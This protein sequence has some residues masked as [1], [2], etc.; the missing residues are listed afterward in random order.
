MS[1]CALQSV[2]RLV[3]QQSAWLFAAL[4]LLHSSKFEDV[5]K[6]CACFDSVAL[7]AVDGPELWA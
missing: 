2:R 3:F 7:V 6:I 1:S 5:S 4:I